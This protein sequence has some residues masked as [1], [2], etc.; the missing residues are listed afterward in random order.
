MSLKEVENWI[1]K[2]QYEPPYKI[3]NDSQLIEIAKGGIE[4]S[5]SEEELLNSNNNKD[6]DEESPNFP[7]PSLDEVL[8]SI[9]QIRRWSRGNKI[10][11]VE[12]NRSLDSL[13]E[14]MYDLAAANTDRKAQHRCCLV[15][16]SFVVHKRCHEYVTFT[17]PG[18]DKG[19]DS[20]DTRTRHNF[21]VHTYS[22]P[23]FCDHCGSLLYGVIHQGMKCT[24]IPDKSHSIK[25]L[26][27]SEFY[28]NSW[29]KEM[30][31]PCDMNVHKRCEES[32]PNLCGCD[33]TE[34]RG[35]NSAENKLLWK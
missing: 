22:S 5:D 11:T 7:P 6:S 35:R 31:W 33:H 19:A 12:E 15:I 29:S 20:D 17:C 30:C 18:A 32:V 24:G 8:P 3:F 1:D 27:R 13:M 14:K 34:R 9:L 26:K 2:D 28:A 23:T 25:F 21:K 10:V 4:E 16:C